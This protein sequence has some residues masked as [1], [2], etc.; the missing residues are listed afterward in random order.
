[1]VIGIDASRAFLRNRT[2]I[3]EYSYQTIAHLRVPLK[4]ERV[5]LYVQDGQIPDFELPRSWKV[6]SLRAPRF[7]THVR[8]SLEMLLHLPD[9]LFVPA[10]TIPF[11]H[12]ARNVTPL[13]RLSFV[14]V[15]KF[16]HPFTG[17]KEKHSV[18]GGPARSVVTVHGLEYEFSKES[19]SRWERFYMRAVIRFSC[20]AAETIIAVSENTKR[21]LIRLYGT[22][23]E[24]I[25]V[26]YE[27]RPKLRPHADGAISNFEFRI[28]K[29]ERGVDSSAESEIEKPHLLFVGRIEERKNVRRIVEAYGL[30]KKR[31]GIPHRLV[32]AG[33]PGYGYA[34]VKRAIGASEYRSDIVETGYVDESK[35]SE[36]LAGADVFVFPSLY[37]GFGL[38]V[39]EAQTVGVPVV[40]SEISSLPDIAGDGAL[41]ADPLSAESIADRIWELLS[42]PVLRGGIIGK[43]RQNAKRFD[44]GRCAEEIAE[45]L[46]K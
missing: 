40:T 46:R 26:V 29:R 14:I 36:L 27:G 30:L 4:E 15:Q 19:Y 44:W 37:E 24:K 21:D 25:R 28:S 11:I 31:H 3:E 20:K 17:C 45:L 42:D 8:L 34:D 16:I 35:K 1:M 22:P 38:P 9:V 12:P 33:K 41:F 5:I 18:A 39:V 10:H 32:L 6:R 23:K 2:G 13:C 7:W 43:G